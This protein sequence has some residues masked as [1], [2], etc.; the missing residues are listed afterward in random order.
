MSDEESPSHANANPRVDAWFHELD[1][2]LKNAMQLVRFIILDAD[3]RITES[4]KWSA[5][6]FAYKGNLASFQPKS[7]RFVSLMFHRGSE[8][9]G[10]HPDLEGEGAL[11]RVMRFEDAADVVA[12]RQ[13]LE[14]VVRAWCD[15]R[16][17]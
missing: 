16:A 6:T 3:D 10:S 15:W 5:P 12:H 2:P 9:P 8:I 4:I 14:K 17:A 13:A 7:K 11:V 1:H